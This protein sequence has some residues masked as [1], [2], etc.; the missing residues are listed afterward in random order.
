MPTINRPGSREIF[1]HAQTVIPGGVNSPVRAYRAVGGEPVVMARGHGSTVWDVDGNA[2]LDYLGSWGPLIF[3]HAPH[4]VVQAV[5]ETAALGTSF[6][7]LTAR[8]VDFAQLLCALVPALA[9]VR[10]VNSGTEAVMSAIR[11][12]RAATGREVIIKFD[13]G[14]HGHSDGLLAKAGSG[15]AT[16]G[17]PGTPGVPAAFAALT[18]T[19]PFN[20]LDALRA[21]L[22]E[23]G[24][25]VACLIGEPVPANMGVVLPAA[26]YWAEVRRLLDG[27]GALLIFDEVITGFRLGLTGGQGWTGVT[28]DL[29]T[30]GKIIGGGLP[31]GAFGGRA[32]LMRQLAPE[33]P[34]YQAGTLSGNPLAV[35]AGLATLHRLQATDPYPAL[36]ART[37][38]L[39]AA[40]R[41]A[42]Q[43]K[44]IPLQVNQIGSLFTAFFTDGPVTDY[45]SAARAD[46]HRYAAFFRACLQRGVMFAPSQ[47]EAA[48]V[49][50][51][52]TDAVIAETI[53]RVSEAL[54]MIG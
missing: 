24:A 21:V 37:S 33:G 30:F 31:V 9:M 10:L 8:E 51:T 40:M 52:H 44:G 11:L 25:E 42:A 34:V 6:G 1:A 23:R 49:S 48:F 5:C 28:P 14:Y 4:E 3:G 39:V 53:T 26:D 19:I 22:R 7:A 45:A 2:Y 50:T 16:Q 18:L 17:I 12:A 27:V 47:F 32:E 54:E 29:C 41:A 35:A 43:A 38:T 13:G 15:I 20:D 46:T 36:A